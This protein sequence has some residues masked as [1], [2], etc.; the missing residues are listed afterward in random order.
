MARAKS[1][2]T[3]VAADAA[4]VAKSFTDYCVIG[5]KGAKLE[6]YKIQLA[7]FCALAK[8]SGLDLDP[9]QC[10]VGGAYR[11]AFVAYCKDNP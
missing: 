10:K 6:R 1:K 5:E 3:T 8:Q 11:S 9:A 2:A 4:P 7:G